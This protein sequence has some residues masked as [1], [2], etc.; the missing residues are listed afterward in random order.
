[1]DAQTPATPKDPGTDRFY[2]SL[3]EVKDF[4]GLTEAATY[5][6]LPDNWA[7][8]VADVM[9][10]TSAIQKGNY[11]AVNTVGVSVIAAVLNVLRPLE[12]PYIFGGDGAVLC[13]PERFSDRVRPALAATLAMAV[14]SFGLILRAAVFPATFLRQQ[15]SDL[16]IARCRVSDH[17][18]QCGLAGGGVEAAESMLKEGSLPAAYVVTPDQSESADYT[19]LECRWQEIR[20]PW[21]ETVAIIVRAN[22]GHPEHLRTHAA[23]LRAVE[24]IYGDG[25]RC[26]PVTEGA[27]R[28]AFSYKVLQNELR[29]KHANQGMLGVFWRL[30]ILRAVVLYGWLLMKLRIRIHDTQWG[31]YK[32]DLVANTDFKKF[33]GAL[34]LVLSGS[35]RQREQLEQVLLWM[36]QRGDVTY[37]IHVADSAI[38]T[39]LVEQRQGGHFHFVDAAGGGYAEAARAIK[40]SGPAGVRW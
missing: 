19:G 37:G 17:Y 26:R 6:P 2:A 16:L 23:V 12:I 30:M 31:D 27:V 8:V 22:A 38:I 7:L 5:T 10:S 33:D 25:E 35:P 20:S 15:G 13:I 34:R 1:M 39:C 29:V 9:N 24:S 36:K 4:S 28:A 32:K 21:G 3:P 11:K 14:R 40:Q 18:V